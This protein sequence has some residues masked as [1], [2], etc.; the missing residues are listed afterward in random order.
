MIVILGDLHF[1]NFKAWSS[2]ICE[3]F[4]SWF[5]NW[6]KNNNSNTLILAGDLVHNHINGGLVIS[7]LER[8]SLYSSFN[9]IHIC[10]GNHDKKRVDSEEQLA[11]DFY[12]YKPNIHIYEKPQEVSIEN[13]RVLFL[14]Y[15]SGENEE[16]YS[17][18][19]YYS[20]LYN[21]KKFTPGYDLI[22]GH[23]CGSDAA[24][25]G[26]ED[27]VSN[28]EKLKA[29][30]ICLGHIHT[31]RVNP[32]QYIGS[33]YANRCNENDY[34]RAAWIW[35]GENWS[36][37]RLPLFNEFLTVVYPE[38]LPHSKAM[39]PIYTILNCGSEKLARDKYGNIFIR[40]V[41][42]TMED[43]SSKE[44]YEAERKFDSVKNMDLRDLFDSFA[45]EQNPPLSSNIIETCLNFLKES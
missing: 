36:E 38:R 37:E 9:S 11:Y 2:K 31:R 5:K 3:D 27:Y 30:K 26:S 21:N 12:R 8:L 22:V 25:P 23:F 1:S 34:K 16:G 10:V 43:Y 42:P 44:K 40:R 33:V 14:P 28:L 6:D 41:L 4:L 29:K 18:S 13:L 39:T 35:D 24:F 17:M 20:L 7:Y 45:K 15:Y 19:D 32:S